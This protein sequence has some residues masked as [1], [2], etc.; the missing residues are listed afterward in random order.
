M[1]SR[2]Y[3]LCLLIAS[4]LIINA[5]SSFSQSF[6]SADA[7]VITIGNK[8]IKLSFERSASFALLNI[9]NELT[10]YSYRFTGIP[11]FEICIF[12]GD[13]VKC[14]TSGNAAS[15]RYKI[16]Q[17]HGMKYISYE[18]DGF[19]GDGLHSLRVSFRVVIPNDAPVTYW[20]ITIYAKRSL[21]IV[22]VKFPNMGRFTRLGEKADDIY[23]VTPTFPGGLIVKNPLDFCCPGYPGHPYP[24]GEQWIQYLALFDAKGAGALYLYTNDANGYYKSFNWEGRGKWATFSVIHYPPFNYLTKYSPSYNVILGV[25][26]ASNWREALKPYKEWASKQWWARGNIHA[27]WLKDTHLVVYSTMHISPTFYEAQNKSGKYHARFSDI[28]KAAER[29]KERLRLYN[30]TVLFLLGGWEKNGQ[31]ASYPDVFPPAEGWEELRKLVDGLHN[32]GFKVGFFI[33]APLLGLEKDLKSCKEERCKHIILDINGGT[34]SD[35]SHDV[36]M[37]P[38]SKYWKERL[39]NISVTLIRKTGADALYYDTALH[40]PINYGGAEEDPKGGGNYSVQ[41][42]IEIFNEVRKLTK[43]VK[44][45]L[46]ILVEQVSEPLIPYVD[47]TYVGSIIF[48]E[49]FTSSRIKTIDLF[50]EIYEHRLVPMGWWVLI[51]EQLSY[52]IYEGR[53][54]W[55]RLPVDDTLTY[56]LVTRLFL[57]GFPIPLGGFHT[58]AF[59]EESMRFLIHDE[60]LH[61][62]EKL[63]YAR[64]TYLKKFLLKGRMLRYLTLGESFKMRCPRGEVD[65]E[66]YCSNDLYVNAV[67]GAEFLS[68]DGDIA[69]ILLNV[70]NR[71]VT[72]S[73]NKT[74]DIVLVDGLPINAS[75]TNSIILHPKKLITM[76]SLNNSLNNY[77][78]QLR[79]VLLDRINA[80]LSDLMERRINTH[81]LQTLENR[82]QQS[83]PKSLTEIIDYASDLEKIIMEPRREDFLLSAPLSFEI[84]YHPYMDSFA[85]IHF[86]NAEIVAVVEEPYFLRGNGIMYISRKPLMIGYP[87]WDRSDEKIG[88]HIVLFHSY[89]WDPHYID[90]NVANVVIRLAIPPEVRNIRMFISAGMW[91]RDETMIKVT[92]RNLKTGEKIFEKMQTGGSWREYDINIEKIIPLG[93]VKVITDPSGLKIYVNGTFMG[94]SPLTLSL[95]PGTYEITAEG[96]RKHTVSVQADKTITINLTKIIQPHAKINETYTT[97]TNTTAKVTLTKYQKTKTTSVTVTEIENKTKVTLIERSRVQ[98]IREP[99]I[100]TIITLFIISGCIIALLV[101]GFKKSRESKSPTY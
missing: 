51:R 21:R 19:K 35:D 99:A 69:T 72:I 61:F 89:S 82:I 28:L 65:L 50:S 49:T 101:L 84:E 85:A 13:I 88:H 23:L 77:L 24:T 71:P 90:L 36:F 46:A 100:N 15:Y 40:T 12:D 57:H 98:A 80:E 31:G 3:V 2:S 41:A 39:T 7:R 78:N 26:A 56:L 42:W 92:V 79:M 29:L 66:N 6:A 1:T 91:W 96:A 25:S 10:G 83:P 45:D 9:N 86:E 75:N 76:I 59:K 30:G 94:R 62:Y 14:F 8:F 37:N 81:E 53:E 20:S 64:S 34:Y 63:A 5:V 52:G 95:Y 68:S 93:L 33:L 97:G 70:W 22:H 48:A 18:A 67:Q 43:D 58:G 60:K 27:P 38:S 16:F 44:P 4:L 55:R 11:I 54:H 74:Y 73:L 32:L 87:H 17:K 47:G